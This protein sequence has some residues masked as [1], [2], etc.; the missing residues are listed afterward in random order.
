[1]VS[2]FIDQPFTT[3]ASVATFHFISSCAPFG[4]RSRAFFTAGSTLLEAEVFP[5]SLPVRFFFAIIGFSLLWGGGQ[6]IGFFGVGEYFLA[7]AGF[8]LVFVGG[9]FFIC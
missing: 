8:S 9:F 2:V 3:L 5:C 6:L 4:A 1:M 7:G